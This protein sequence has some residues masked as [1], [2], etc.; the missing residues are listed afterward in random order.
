MVHFNYVKRCRL[1]IYIFAKI[2]F[3][4]HF[5]PLRVAEVKK[6][7]SDCVSVKF[8]IPAESAELFKFTQGQY[9]TLRVDIDG[10]EVRRSYSICS[11][12]NDGELRVAVKEVEGGK[13]STYANRELKAGDVIEAMPPM[14]NFFV[15]LDPSKKG[16]YTAFVAGSGITPVLSIIKT[17]LE[18]EH[19]SEFTLFYSNRN[20][21]GIIF[22]E[23]LEDL[24]DR[25][26]NRLRVFHLLS[27][28][29]SEVVLFAGRIDEEKCTALCNA[30]LD[31]ENTDA[32]FIC[33]PEPMIHGV[34]D[35]LHKSGVAKE[36]VLFELFTSPVVGALQQKAEKASEARY[37][38]QSAQV[39][40]ILDGTSMTFDLPYDG[41]NVLDAALALGA[42]L[43]FACKGG[44]CCTCR[45]KLTE[46]EVHMAVNYSLEE[47]E[48]ERGFILTCQ[49]HPRSG[50]IV[51]DFDQQ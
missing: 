30:L 12:V 43:P 32:F 34:K 6:E 40:L 48:V 50:K 28:E 7:T 51:V 39:E 37:S 13:F 49:S 27:R 19:E 9:V 25:Y 44:V 5:H 17:T 8:D 2:L 36:K 47:E 24:K 21:G 18:T 29:T 20:F 31:V 45:A 46:G 15:K 10:E 33:G 11:G 16:S 23:A 22:R 4:R 42:D 14:G 35:S 26:M 41:K 1:H 3:M 38:G